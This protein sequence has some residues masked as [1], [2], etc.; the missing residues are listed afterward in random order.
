MESLLSYQNTDESSSE[1]LAWCSTG[2]NK[3]K[4]VKLDGK[5]EEYANFDGAQILKRGID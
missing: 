3:I 4:V 1:L 5:Q 2:D